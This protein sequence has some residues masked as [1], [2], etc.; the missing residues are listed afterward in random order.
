MQ[1]AALFVYLIAVVILLAGTATVFY[2]FYKFS[3]GGGHRALVFVFVAGSAFLFLAGFAAFAS[4]DWEAILE[5]GLP[6]VE[7][8][9]LP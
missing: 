1:A 3:V 9:L 4:I 2:H 5:V 6:L 8:Q 7:S